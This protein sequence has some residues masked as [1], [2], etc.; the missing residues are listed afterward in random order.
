MKKSIMLSIFAVLSTRRM[1]LGAGNGLRSLAGLSCLG[2]GGGGLNRGKGAV[3]AF[4]WENWAP[5]V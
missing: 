1:C 2:G 5:R 3:G 4:F